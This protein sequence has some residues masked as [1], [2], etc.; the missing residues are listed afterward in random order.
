M[1]NRESLKR[2]GFCI[3]ENKYNHVFI[4]LRLETNDPDYEFRKYILQ[5]FFSVDKKRRATDI[6]SRHFR[7]YF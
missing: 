5:K 6:K 3:S 2:Y 7:V 4:K 1:S